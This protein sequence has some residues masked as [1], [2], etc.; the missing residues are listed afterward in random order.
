MLSPPKI[1]DHPFLTPLVP[2]TYLTGAMY[3]FQV[4]IYCV[5]EAVQGESC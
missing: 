3:T 1:T 2:A 4:R 5:G